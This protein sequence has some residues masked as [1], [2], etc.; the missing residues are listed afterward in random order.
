MQFGSYLRIIAATMGFF[1]VILTIL[2]IVYLRAHQAAWLSA[3]PWEKLSLGAVKKANG[4]KELSGI[5][6]DADRFI[7]SGP[8]GALGVQ[9]RGAAGF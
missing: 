3:V 8:R 1:G 2:G 4:A 7:Y 5:R 6:A 9:F